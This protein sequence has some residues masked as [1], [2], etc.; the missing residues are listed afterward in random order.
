MSAA[1]AP[2]RLRN[3]I[4]TFQ[5]FALAFGAVVGAGW[6]VVLGDWLRQAGPL[7]AILG[8]AS[9]GLIVVLIG[10]CYGEISTMLPVSGGEVAF[11]YEVFGERASFATGWLLALAY[12][13]VTAFEAISIGWI[14]SALWPGIEGPVLYR[15]LGVD[16]RAGALAFGL[17]GMAVLGYLNVRGAKAATKTQGALVIALLLTAVVFIIAG[18][19]R[20]DLANLRPYFQRNAAGSI[21]PGLLAIFMTAPFWFGG[22]EVVPKA[23]EEKSPGTQLRMVGAMIV[24]S[25][26]IGIVFKTSVILSA[27]M[28]MPWRELLSAKIPVESAFRVAFGSALLAKLVL[29]TALLGLLTTWNAMIVAAS[30]VFYSL[31]RASFIS[32]RYARVHSRFGSPGFAV[33]F[34]CVV[35]ASATLLGR[36]ALIPIVNMTATCITLVYLLTCLA[37][38]RLRRTDA[39]RERPFRVPGGAVTAWAAS[40]GAA[41]SLAL[42]LYQPYVDAKGKVPLEWVVLALW[43]LL[44][45]LFWTA[46]R[47]ARRAMSAVERRAII[48]GQYAVTP[49]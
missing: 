20:G 46:G 47:S 12:T 33:I 5:F 29:V 17:G 6:A 4:G 23:L 2:S 7:G 14:V 15:S 44:G 39:A 30:R 45:A 13:V 3:E 41:F 28:T 48:T 37:V 38:V 19:G 42:S 32:R 22:F 21:W 9:G 49:R 34:T 43:L 16:V 8:L 18:I 35:G 36:N 10:L 31:G 27:S 26:A 11:A 25:I 1:A 40:G 24:L